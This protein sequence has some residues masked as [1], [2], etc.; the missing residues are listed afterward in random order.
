MAEATDSLAATKIDDKDTINADTGVSGIIIQ[1]F[2]NDI[3]AR[4]FDKE[5]AIRQASLTLT[6]HILKRSLVHPIQVMHSEFS[7]YDHDSV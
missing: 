6:I 5:T 4:L 7:S 2:L 1:Q 3:L